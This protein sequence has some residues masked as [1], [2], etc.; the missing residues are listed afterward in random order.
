MTY[1]ELNNC[2]VGYTTSHMGKWRRR[3]YTNINNVYKPRIYILLTFKQ[4]LLYCSKWGIYIALYTL[5]FDSGILLKHILLTHQIERLFGIFFKYN[6]IVKVKCYN[7]QPYFYES[8]KY[9]FWN[10]ILLF[11]FLWESDKS[12]LAAKHVRLY[13]I[14]CEKNAWY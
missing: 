2:A 3:A 1:L 5:S 4:V 7:T 8:L 12:V 11:V 6:T 10:M 9:H 14:W 13:R